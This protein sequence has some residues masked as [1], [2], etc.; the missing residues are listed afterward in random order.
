[1]SH[2]SV[3]FENDVA[4]LVL[5]NPPQNR[6]GTTMVDELDAAL[7]EIAAGQ[8]RAVLLRAE[9]PDFSFGGDIEPW[10]GW[11]RQEMRGHFEHFL[12][13]FNRFERLPI[14]TIAAVRGLCFGGGLELAV[15][16]DLIFAGAT[17]RFGHP[18]QSIAIV[19]LLGGIYRIAE[20]AG[21]SRA[22][23]WALTSEQVPAAEMER[24][25]VVDRVVDDDALDE[26]AAAFAARLATGP[27]LAHAAH[28]SLLRTWAVG[29]VS[30]A[31]E[32]IFDVAMPLFASADTRMAIPAAVDA[33]HAGRPR[34]PMP[35]EGR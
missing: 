26:E 19:T 7:G 33:L 22:M 16:A 11:E 25:G 13:T 2:L 4:T 1:M 18:E 20:R 8:A 23:R 12:Q 9:G 6:I 21:R 30:A 34:P 5:H 17:A 31:D 10:P 14:P 27:T 35:F 28:K 29:G 24:F 32:A 15:R 3:T